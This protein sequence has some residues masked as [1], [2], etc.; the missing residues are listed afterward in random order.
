M[1][2]PPSSYVGKMQQAATVSTAQADA[3]SQSQGGAARG[4]FNSTQLLEREE[5]N[6]ARH[7]PKVSPHVT[8]M[9]LGKHSPL[10]PRVEIKSFLHN[11]ATG[12]QM[13]PYTQSP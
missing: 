11:A 8:G 4:G 5:N 6:T 1:P 9:L 10:Q 3:A 7:H 13:L 12:L 2:I